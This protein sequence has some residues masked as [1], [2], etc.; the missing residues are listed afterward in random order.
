MKTSKIIKTI[1]AIL[2]SLVLLGGSA[3]LII[4][5]YKLTGI[6]TYYRYLTIAFVIFLNLVFING[7]RYSISKNKKIRYVIVLLLALI[8]GGG[9][10]YVGYYIQEIYSRL[11]A[12]NKT[13]YEYSSA[14]ITFDEKYK[15]IETL[16]K[17]KIGII[18]DENDIEGYILAK[19][20]LEK[21]GITA[22]LATYEEPEDLIYALYNKRVDAS[23]VPADYV[24]M[25]S[26]HDEF[27]DIEEKA[28]EIDK[29]TKDFTE[30]EVQE[31]ESR[32][33][34]QEETTTIKSMTEPFTVLLLGVDSTANKL[35][36]NA[37]FN[38][39]TIMLISFNPKTMSATMFSVPRDTYV[40][41]T[42]S[43]NKYKKINS[44]AYG[45]SKCMINTLEQWTGI[46]I[47]YYVKIN[48]KGVVDLVNSLGGI[49]VDVPMEFC[50]QNSKRKF[51]KNL[52]CLKPG[53]QHLNG[54][55]AL[56]LARHRKTLLLGDFTRGQNQ[57]IVVEG[58][59]NAIKNLR[60]ANDVL[61]VLDAIKNNI[62]MNM[63]TK[64]ILSL[65]DV[66]KNMMF[67]KDTNMLNIQKTFLRGYDMYV[68]SGSINIYSFH[69]WNGSLKDIVNAMKV[70]LGQKKATVVK[71]LN[72]SLNKEYERYIAGNGYY[73][74]T[75]RTR[76]PSF[77]GKSLTYAKSWLANN[78]ISVSTTTV[79]CN[80]S[81]YQSKYGGNIVIG[82]SV[83]K[84]TL[85][86]NVSSIKLTLNPT[87][88]TSTPD[89]EP[90]TD[91]SEDNSGE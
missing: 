46:D 85:S 52:I 66:A 60:S 51:G 12:F 56:A 88:K 63:K 45:G 26:T 79:S 81:K 77:T 58:M 89:P 41:V 32:Y 15:D 38:G 43:G 14:L 57:Q 76:I 67:N 2:A 28:I 13:T 34:E 49:D 87:C 54:E 20:I 80:S 64:E 11:N 78:G 4:Y 83:H 30:E 8:I 23:L 40:K 16:N 37:A 1:I 21:N 24:G 31:I 3:L 59:M 82:Q 65:Y 25:Y 71:K 90:T 62:D 68:W 70:T 44:A 53:M 22:T 69:N 42:C 35:N 75:R 61:S 50:E 27:K 72:F 19:E 6:E 73:S 5:L 36:K 55:Q 86:L 47:D 7:L 39:D 10:G 9:L 29:I 48:F 18:S 17:G 33:E 74:E 84:N 91:P